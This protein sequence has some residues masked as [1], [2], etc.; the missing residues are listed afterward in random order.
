MRS[1]PSDCA[2][3]ALPFDNRFTRLGTWTGSS[4]MPQPLP[5]PY[6]VSHSPAA[7]ALLGIQSDGTAHPPA[8]WPR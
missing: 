3:D 2:F 4:V 7:A 6:W 1:P 5:D 8:R